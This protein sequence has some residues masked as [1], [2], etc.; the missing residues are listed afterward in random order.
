[1]PDL[2]LLYRQ[3]LEQCRP[4]RLAR[5]AANRDMPGNVV[6][7]GKCAGPLLDGVRHSVPVQKA[8]AAIPRGYP[9]PVGSATV[10]RGGHPSIDDDSFRA[11]QT[12]LQFIDSCDEVLFLISG[13]AS[14][15]V[16]VPLSSW[17]TPA[18]LID[19]NDRLLNAGLP[20]AD[21]NAVRKH[22]SAIK[23]G[24]LAAR[25]PGRTVT[26][27]YSDVAHGDHASVGSGP[28]VPDST[29]TARAIEILRK[30]GG[31]DRIISILRKE[32]FPDTVKKLDN[33]SSSVIADNGTLVRAAAVEAKQ[34]GFEVIGVE[35]QLEAGV[36]TIA[37]QLADR[38]VI[39]EPGQ[40]LIAGGEPTVAI[41]GGGKG[42]R[43]SELAVRFALASRGATVPLQALFASSDG[44]DGNSGAAGIVL[45]TPVAINQSEAA[46]ALGRSD[47]FPLAARL[48]RAVIIPPTGNNLRDLYLVAR[49]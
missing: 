15:C 16:E 18:D 3:T 28:T 21:M 47:S 6:A 24:R 5:S 1:M 10:V 49:P 46:S 31:L 42:G 38:A 40:I 4:N 13:G 37:Q 11:G 9:S 34:A 48:G 25:V 44:V 23:G 27:I 29:T 7:L 17:F 2:E 26:L 36:E 20:I 39:L 12:L 22:L 43:C 19:V 41:R 33:A 30:L 14:A 35:E 45:D 32:S 8:F